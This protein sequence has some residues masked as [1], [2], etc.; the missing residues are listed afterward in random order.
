MA[1]RHFGIYRDVTLDEAR[2]D[3]RIIKALLRR[4]SQNAGKLAGY[5]GERE[6]SPA[7]VAALGR[8]ADWKLAEVVP[9]YHGDSVR[10][11]LTNGGKTWAM[12]L[13]GAERLQEILDNQE[14]LKRQGRE[15]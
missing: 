10:V 9:A 5:V 14:N 1:I 8:L 11:E 4:G 12:E 13:I 15:E 7:F 2:L 6:K 3:G